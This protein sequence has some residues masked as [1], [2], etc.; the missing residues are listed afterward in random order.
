[1]LGTAVQ[2]AGAG[3]CYTPKL[4]FVAAG[5]DDSLNFPEAFPPSNYI[6]MSAEIHKRVSY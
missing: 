3:G 1:M 2:A 4:P 5:N 6:C